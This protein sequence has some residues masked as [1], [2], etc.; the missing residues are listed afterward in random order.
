MADPDLAASWVRNA[1]PWTEAVRSGS[2]ASR[3]LATDAAIVAAVL[4]RS[5]RRAL[6]LGC[7]EGWL[8]RELSARGV[9]AVG[10]DAS[11]P[12]VAA[13][14]TA[15]GTFL[16]L[17]HEAIAAEPARVGGPFDVVIANF[18]LL[19]DDLLPLL[20]AIS[21]AILPPGGALLIQTLHPLAAG[22]PYRDGWRTEDFKGFGA[23]AG[24]APMPWYFR[25]LG[26]WLALLDAAG[27][28]RTALR[29]PLHPA[30]ALPL[31]LLLIAEP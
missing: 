25:T 7:G 1:A 30:T 16:E 13:A 29:E 12:L 18:A 24:W 27:F 23:E 2:I 26:S 11:A 3:R 10:T 28:R 8:C 15:G 5:P 21:S 20:R 31:S 14:R 19:G 6:D 9:A 17:S 22:A 4:E